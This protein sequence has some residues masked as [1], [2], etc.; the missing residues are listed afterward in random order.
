MLP[1]SL[2]NEQIQDF[3]LLFEAYISPEISQQYPLF[4]FLF[5]FFIFFYLVLLPPVLSDSATPSNLKTS[6]F[7]TVKDNMMLNLNFLECSAR[8]RSKTYPTC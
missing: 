3:Q 7:L 2:F 6:T 5:S 1:Q 4:V 8:E